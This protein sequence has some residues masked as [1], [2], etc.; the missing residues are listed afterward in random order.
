MRTQLGR[1]GCNALVLRP[2]AADGSLTQRARMRAPAGCTLQRLCNNQPLHASMS[3]KQA[4]TWLLWRLPCSFAP[5]VPIVPPG[6]RAQ[7]DSPK[8]NHSA[9]THLH[10]LTKYGTRALQDIPLTTNYSVHLCSMLD[11]ATFTR[12]CQPW[13]A[14]DGRSVQVRHP[15]LSQNGP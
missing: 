4:G 9:P 15:H 6:T 14:A 12:H 1:P 8:T 10:Y 13:T 11:G 2:G 7:R 5:W 3:T